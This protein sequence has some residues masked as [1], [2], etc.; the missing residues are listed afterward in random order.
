[1][2]AKKVWLLVINLIGGTAVLGSYVY[3]FQVRADAGQILWGG[4]P[5]GIRPY[6][7]LGMFLAA[8]GY[9]AFTYFI[10]F[11]LN[12]NDTRVGSRF[13]YGLFNLLYVVIL[14][15]SALWMPLTLLAIEQGSPALGWIVRLVLVIVAVAS[16]GLFAA[17]LKVHPRRPT[18]AHILALVGC[19]GFCFQTVLLDAIFWG[20]FFQV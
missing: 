13:G 7:T 2:S 17:L 8:T 18:W 16:L 9:F 10:L 19:V 3:G 12:V 6:Y 15:F 11:R 20:F 5:E 1:M 4:V 14:F